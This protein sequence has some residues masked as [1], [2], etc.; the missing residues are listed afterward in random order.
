MSG[1]ICNTYHLK[2]PH[3]YEKSEI[4]NLIRLKISKNHQFFRREG[5]FLTP[6]DFL[7]IRTTKNTLSK[8]TAKRL[9]RTYRYGAPPRQT[10]L[11]HSASEVF[12]RLSFAQGSLDGAPR[13]DHRL[14]AR[15]LASPPP[16]P[17][18]FGPTRLAGQPANRSTAPK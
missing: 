4:Y 9:E 14:P 6:L 18:T 15:A 8:T 11:T 3:N 5:S 10:S 17:A 7:V 2:K 12:P 1:K 16:Q 13:A